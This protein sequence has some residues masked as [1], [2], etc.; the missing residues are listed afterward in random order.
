ML[1]LNIRTVAVFLKLAELLITTIL[2]ATH[3]ENNPKR[4]KAVP[5]VFK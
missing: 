2:M 3:E 5:V 4:S 1:G